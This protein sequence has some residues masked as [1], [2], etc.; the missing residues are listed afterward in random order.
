MKKLILLLTFLILA[1]KEDP[2]IA[3]PDPPPPPTVINDTLEVSIIDFTH[4]SIV[5]NVKN[6]KN[7]PNSFVELYRTEN[8]IGYL[9]AEYPITIT[10]TTI[11]DDNSGNDLELNTEY[12]Y[13]VVRRD[14]SGARKDTSSIAYAA[15]LEA[16]AFNYTWEEFSIGSS[17]YGPN[18]LYDV[19]GSSETDVWAVGGFYD[20]NNT[21]YGA[22]HYNGSE[23]TPD[24]TAGG[25]AI[26]GFSA[27]DIWTAGGGV[28]HF[29][30]SQWEKIDSYSSGNQGI[31]LDEVLYNNRPYSSIWGTSSNN[32]YFGNQ[33]GVI[34]HWN[35]TNASVVYTHD[36]QVAVQDLD[37]YSKDYILGVGI[38]LVP[39]LLV[40]NYDGSNWNKLTV[41]NDPSMYSVA[42]LTKKLSYF[43]GN[44]IY[45][46][47][48]NSFSRTYT[49]GYEMYD[50][51]YNHQNG[52]IAACGPFDGIYINNGIEWRDYRG[53][54]TSENIRYYNIFM[55]NNT[56]FCV[57]STLNEAKIIVGKNY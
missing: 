24:S 22:L 1:C 39:P 42:I 3:P 46:M 40:V 49:S 57:G 26:H 30:G 36:S 2:P 41:A 32:L 15:T 51:E 9:V 18:V 50:V 10:D 33:R 56:I 14:T 53:Q 35:G 6:T 7:N 34:V 27:N 8:R 54:I 20:D 31:P 37:G 48:D 17:Q 29:N 19:W 23:W 38:G 52:V 45:Q 28:Y 4:I 55:I 21:N 5:V 47:R 43:A 25:V 44:G 16:T 12:G 13:Y 11:V